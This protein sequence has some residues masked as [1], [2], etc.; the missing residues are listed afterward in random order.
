MTMA[1]SLMLADLGSRNDCCY[2]KLWVVR[3]Q[4]KIRTPKPVRFRDGKAQTL[5]PYK[6]P[7]AGPKPKLNPRTLEL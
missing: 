3:L 5:K 7:C 4:G 6:E 2:F 1:W